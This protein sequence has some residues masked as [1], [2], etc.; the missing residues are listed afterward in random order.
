[1]TPFIPFFVLFCH[2]VQKNDKDDLACLEKFVQS[3]EAASGHYGLVDNH[4]YS[5]EIEVIHQ[6]LDALRDSEKEWKVRYEIAEGRA[7]HL[8]YLWDGLRADR[9]LLWHRLEDLARCE[10]ALREENG[11]LKERIGV[12]ERAHEEL[13]L[14]RE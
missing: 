9:E 6:A 12:L 2:V 1:M 7:K 8:Q 5:N 11:A 3:I 14:V 10:A 13:L 4:V